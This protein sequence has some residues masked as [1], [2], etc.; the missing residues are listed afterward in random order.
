M[1][2]ALELLQFRNPSISPVASLSELDQRSFVEWC[3]RKQITLLLGSLAGHSMP[4][5][6]L[7]PIRRRTASYG[8]RFERLKTELFQVTE[9]L[10]A[11]H[12]EFVM[13]KGLSHA[14]ALTPEARLRAQGDIDLWLP[15]ESVER[16]RDILTKLGYVPLLQSK[17]RHLAPMGRPSSWRW[18]GGDMFDPDMPVSVELH[19]ELWSEQTEHIAVPGIQ[20]FWVRRKVREFDGHHL[21]VL[22]DEDLVAFSALHFLLH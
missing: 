20:Q 2:S 18:G 12:L 3:D 6:L 9:A 13:L 5:W 21:H 15:R 11:G 19:Y 17:A 4:L 1:L 16:A 7:E 22:C 14:P 10:D 8:C